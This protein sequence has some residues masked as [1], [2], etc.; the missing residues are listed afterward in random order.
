[1][2]RHARYRKANKI[3]DNDLLH[4][5]GDGLFEIFNVVEREEWRK[6]TDVEK[7]AIG[8]FHKNLGE[9]MEIPFDPLVSSKYGWT[10]GLHFATEL[11][12]WTLL[13]EQ[14]VAKPVAT[15]D[16]YVR[17]YVDSAMSSLPSFIRTAMR[18]MLGA[19]L[20]DVMRTSLW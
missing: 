19:S 10:D 5:L 4:T 16:Q 15:N 20:D 2:P 18:Q 14:E 11:A 1:M 13:Y 9:D 7:C 6:L 17:V 12:D 8:V 3:T